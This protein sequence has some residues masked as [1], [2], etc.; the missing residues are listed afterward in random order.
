MRINIIF[1]KN[2]NTLFAGN[3]LGSDGKIFVKRA[4][5]RTELKFP[6]RA[7]FTKMIRAVLSSMMMPQVQDMVIR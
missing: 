4:V 7:P 3:S 5:S 6:D 1:N 2:I